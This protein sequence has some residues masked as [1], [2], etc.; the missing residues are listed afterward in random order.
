VSVGVCSR[1]GGGRCVILSPVR[2]TSGVECMIGQ[3]LEAGLHTR[4][5]QGERSW[6]LVMDGFGCSKHR[7]GGGAVCGLD[8]CGRAALAVCT[9][10]ERSSKFH[11]G[12]NGCDTERS[13]RLSLQIKRETLDRI[14]SEG[15]GICPSHRTYHIVTS[16]VAL[17]RSALHTTGVLPSAATVAHAL[18]PFPKFQVPPLSETAITALFKCYFSMACHLPS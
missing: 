18:W 2:K 12:F 17:A 1:R 14:T 3:R 16:I 7:R 15:H 8:V 13:P 11:V 5:G 10:F 6:W 9:V 4:I